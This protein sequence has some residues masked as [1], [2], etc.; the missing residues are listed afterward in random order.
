MDIEDIEIGCD[1]CRATI[2]KSEDCYCENCL[3]KKNEEIEALEKK[4]EGLESD[5][6][7]YVSDLEELRETI[8]RLR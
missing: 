8:K 4:I 7:F 2:T 3:E 6:S 5:I 1:G